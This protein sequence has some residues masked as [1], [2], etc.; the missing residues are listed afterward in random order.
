[1]IIAYQLI[2]Q[3]IQ[4]VASMMLAITFT[5]TLEVNGAA[6]EFPI[7]TRKRVGGFQFLTKASAKVS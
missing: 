4:T 5:W 2:M 7:R 1:M 3:E 6:M